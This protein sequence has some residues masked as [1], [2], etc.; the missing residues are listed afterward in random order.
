MRYVLTF[1][2]LGALIAGCGGSDDRSF[3]VVVESSL[4]E[5]LQDSF[6]QY[7]ETM[8]LAQFEVHVES[9]VPGTVD[10]LKGLL[11]DYADR[12]GIEG[13]LLIGDL[14][15][16]WYEQVGPEG[17][18]HFPTDIYLQD[19][20]AIWVDTNN[21]GI[22]DFHEDLDLDIY[23]ARLN[24]TPTQLQDY[25]GRAQHYRSVG[26]LVDVSAFIFI[27][28]DWSTTDTSDAFHLDELYSSVE[29][30]QDKADS[31]RENYLAKLTG[32]GAEFVYQKIHA[33]P[34]F[35]NFDEHLDEHGELVPRKLHASDIAED[36]LK[37]SFLNMTNCSAARF[38]TAGNVAEAYTVG[39]GYGLAIIG[40]TKVGHLT[41]P[42][43][44]HQNLVQ[45]M[46]W[47]EA[48]RAW[49]NEEG[50]H[51]DFWY[52][53]VVIMG[54]PLVRL[55]GDLFPSGG[56]DAAVWDLRDDTE[57]TTSECAADVELGTFEEYRKGHPEFFADSSVSPI[58][59]HLFY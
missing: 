18:E 44:F 54:D 33:G 20:D 48:Y 7:A 59:R 3:L 32:D 43:L 27:D 11:F 28:D 34:L 38:T 5:P 53:G 9:W 51:N 8:R 14:P 15:A 36:N 13:A 40:S 41:D 30:I 6:E 17:Y 29:I 24:G 47:G 58:A 42:R 57:G 39:T 23:T 1:V 25:F 22:F 12:H 16:A 52:L 31:T 10:E 55:T 50:K 4:H 49:Y 37:V 46:R 45:G 21:S 56:T 35:L 26:S 19:R 2:L